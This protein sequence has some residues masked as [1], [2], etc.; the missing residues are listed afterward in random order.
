MKDLIMKKKA[1]I[2]EIEEVDP[3]PFPIL[4]EEEL[5]YEEEIINSIMKNS[6]LNIKEV[7]E[8][9]VNPFLVERQSTPSEEE[10]L[11]YKKK[12]TALIKIYKW[13]PKN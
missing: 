8:L 11:S 2:K 10:N 6:E 5:D 1:G 3:D 13:N 12:M 4:E 9:V 7:E